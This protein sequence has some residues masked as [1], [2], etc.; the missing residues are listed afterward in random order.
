[1][2]VQ[3]DQRGHK[4]Y[5]AQIRLCR[6][7]QVHREMLDHK[8]QREPI[9]RCRVHRATRDRSG[10]KVPRDSKVSRVSRVILGLRERTAQASHRASSSCGRD[11]W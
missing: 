6:V 10:R 3:P 2:T 1:M 9:Q 8:E 7:Q 4:V 11:W 5:P